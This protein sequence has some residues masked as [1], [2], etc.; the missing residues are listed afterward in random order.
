MALATRAAVGRILPVA[1]GALAGA[2][3]AWRAPDAATDQFYTTSA[4]I[5]PVLLLVLA[6]EARIFGRPIRLLP[7]GDMAAR[8]IEYLRRVLEGGTLFVLLIAEWAA[9]DAI[10]KD[11]GGIRDPA[12]VY[13]GL[14]WG[15]FTASTLAFMGSGRPRVTMELKARPIGE[16]GLL[17]EVSCGNVHGDKPITGTMNLLFPEGR[18][19]W[20]ADRSGGPGQQLDVGGP[21]DE[22]FDGEDRSF[23]YGYFE[24][25]IP[26]GDAM[27]GRYHLQLLNSEEV[28]MIARLDHVDLP[29]G[30]VEDRKWVSR[31]GIR[32]EGAI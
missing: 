15:F 32:P 23:E 9:L 8:R 20:R 6:I 26:P 22:P 31:D 30:R 18:A 25:D 13:F 3:A 2:F 17:V 11:G 10:L 28:P 16:H 29:G 14:T 24:A 12:W 21:V 4:Q 27:V 7:K 19:L 5:L 1:V